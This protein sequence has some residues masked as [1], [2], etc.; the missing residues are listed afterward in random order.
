MNNQAV[1]WNEFYAKADMMYPAE[2]V[3]RMFKG[4]YPNL[5]M[6]KPEQGDLIAD[7]GC[8]DG[9]HIPLFRSLGME[10][11]GTEISEEIC[12]KVRLNI[13]ED[14]SVSIISSMCHD[15]QIPDAVCDY[16]IAWNSIYYMNAERPFSEHVS[17]MKRILKPN[18]WLIVSVPK[19]PDCFIFD[20]S[21]EHDDGKNITIISEYFG[22]RHGEVMRIFKGRYDLEYAFRPEFDN[23]YHADIDINCFGLR[24][25]WWV[26]AAQ[27]VCSGSQQ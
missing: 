19:Y 13:G 6:D 20:D 2:M 9:R 23:F 12:D 14:P 26:F 24:Y 5:N 7:I 18:G 3:I 4:T 11:I 15:L 27:A 1:N 8:G 21:K 17:E 16:A 25:S 10:V 22:I